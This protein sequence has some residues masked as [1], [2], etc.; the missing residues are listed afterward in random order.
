MKTII[1][2][3]AAASL[4]NLGLIAMPA[5]IDPSLAGPTDAQRKVLFHIDPDTALLLGISTDAIAVQPA[6][7][8]RLDYAELPARYAGARFD[9][10]SYLASIF[11]TTG[12]RVLERDISDVSNVIYVLSKTAATKLGLIE[13]ADTI[14]DDTIFVT[15]QGDSAN[16]VLDKIL[17]AGAAD[18]L[19]R[20]SIAS[21]FASDVLDTMPT[22]AA[23]KAN[24]HDT[25]AA[26]V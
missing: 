16:I 20:S 23:I 7:A 2:G 13:N 1:L 10:H 17:D 3:I 15:M 25:D 21:F 18:V 24:G 8:V 11:D 14:D 12:S 19:P 6:G 22:P 9:G 4:N 26:H 5:L